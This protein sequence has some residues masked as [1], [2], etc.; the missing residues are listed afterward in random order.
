M[1]ASAGGD[2]KTTF[3]TLSFHLVGSVTRLGGR[4]F[5]P[6]SHLTGPVSDF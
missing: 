4:Y 6:V 5:A 2:Q 3:R 1:Y